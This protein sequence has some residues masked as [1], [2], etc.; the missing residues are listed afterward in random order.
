MDQLKQQIQHGYRTN[1]VSSDDL[2]SLEILI[3]TLLKPIREKKKKQQTEK[4]KQKAWKQFWKDMENISFEFEIENHPALIS[5]LNEI[6]R[7]WDIRKWSGGCIGGDEGTTYRH[8]ST[9]PYLYSKNI[10]LESEDGWSDNLD[11]SEK[12]Y[13]QIMKQLTNLKNNQLWRYLDCPNCHDK[14]ECLKLN[15]LDEKDFKELLEQSDKIIEVRN[16]TNNPAD[17]HY[18][19]HRTSSELKEMENNL[20]KLLRFSI[21]FTDGVSVIYLQDHHFK[22]LDDC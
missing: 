12:E 19:N 1:Q 11:I 15:D 5:Y 3:Q 20:E 22:E 6:G 17:R 10:Y 7:E 2:E 14:C 21:G 8:V 4:D 13:G 16:Y 18:L 9:T